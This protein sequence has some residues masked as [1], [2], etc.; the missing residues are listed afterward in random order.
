MLNGIQ[1]LTIDAKGRLVIPSKFRE[2][3]LVYGSNELMVTL[4]RRDSLLLYPK[5]EWKAVE[6]QLLALPV[7]S[8]LVLRR[9]QQLVLSHAESVTMDAMGR[10]LLPQSLRKLVNFESEVT[11]VGRGNRM[12]LWSRAVWD[13][14]VQAALDID[15]NILA[16]EL[17]KTTL[18]L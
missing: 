9:F 10:V 4:E 5:H 14:Q 15:E 13:E 8:N 7:Q 18:R 11:L 2:P 1:E 17:G 12:E 16:E 3:L 6:A